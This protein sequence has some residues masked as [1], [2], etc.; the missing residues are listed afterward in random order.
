MRQLKLL[1]RELRAKEV[2]IFLLALVIGTAAV[3][4][5]ALLAERLESGVRSYS[6]DLLGGDLEISSRAPLEENILSVA[7]ANGL[8]QADTLAT[9][10]MLYAAKT[11]LFQLARLKAVSADYP[12]RGA[13][14]IK[15]DLAEGE[16]Y[17]SASPKPGTLWLDEQVAQML[18]ASPGD[19]ISVGEIDLI[20]TA[21][22]IEE[23][24]NSLFSFT[25]RAMMNM[26]DLPRTEL[27]R[28]GS[29]VRYEYLWSGADQA[30][31]SFSTTVGPLLA[32]NQRLIRA[33]DE[34]ENFSSM[35]RRLR[36][37]LMLSGSLS[38]ILAAF[39][40][41]LTIRYYIT[42]NGRYIALLKTIGYTPGRV[43][44]YLCNKLGWLSFFA[45]VC[46]CFI[47]WIFYEAVATLLTDILPAEQGG[48]PW[49]AF[50]M[51]GLSTL[52]CLSAF[53]LPSLI[54]L[55]RT[56]PLRVL[57]AQQSSV[58]RSRE[59]IIGGAMGI[60][61]LALV[62]LYSRNWI[63]TLSLFGGLVGMLLVISLLTYGT[64][65]WFHRRAGR[66][67]ILWRIAAASL[68]R[69]WR[70]N[71]LQILAFSLALMLFGILLVLRTSFVSEWQ[72]RIAPGTPNN[73]LI[74]IA[75]VEVRQVEEFF[76]FN[77]VEPVPF[78][79]MVRGKLTTVDGENLVARTRRLGTYNSEAEREFN[80]GWSDSLPEHNELVA[81]SWWSDIS[82]APASYP[83]SVEEDL[84]GEF[85]IKIGHELEFVIGGRTLIATVANLRA[86]D[87]ADFKPNFYVL[88]PSQA[89]TD[90]PRTF[91]TSFYLPAGKQSFLR[92]LVRRFPT[93][94][95]ISVDSILKRVSAIFALVSQAMQLVLLL[96]LLA[97][98]AVFL[99]T[100]QVSIR[101]RAITTA[102]MRLIGETN[103]QAVLHNLLE[104]AFL[105]IMAGLLAVVGTE[106]VVFCAY[107]FLLEQ[108]FTLHLYLWLLA[109]PCGMILTTVT[110]FIW[111]RRAVLVPPHQL[112]KSLD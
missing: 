107:R 67:G 27:V 18:E 16:A 55:A 54:E 12:L 100:V 61:L 86:V 3:T 112:L 5:P 37:F 9:R 14:L 62:F 48:F 99:A 109:P 32:V 30:L 97:A 19:R 33:G 72:S 43:L 56:S 29:R 34:N 13:L 39:A 52:L 71:S 23:P 96:S 110:G 104:F 1:Q 88:F 57:R 83:V 73:F 41:M 42:V 76:R 50:A 68:Y 78:A 49:F 70:L 85:G 87:W 77:E 11:D 40:L 2:Q 26:E 28:L 38:V 8:R 95:L 75:P 66:L 47:G 15:K 45:Y 102:T 63:I 31:S 59:W 24:S 36:A 7:R 17:R 101:T 82:A 21:Y 64:L 91:I 98:M 105:G 92:D 69:N 53:A 46:G 89:L 90:F 79:G 74:N 81:G 94:S 80:L 25:P 93:L 6:A 111:S 65:R 35:I 44:F 84:A 108:E 106:I 58:P 51:S 4:A 10:S 60:G 22:L 20:F 103:R